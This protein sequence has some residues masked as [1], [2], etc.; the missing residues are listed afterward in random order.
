[1]NYLEL[2]G[3]LGRLAHE[4]ATRQFISRYPGHHLLYHNVLRLSSGREIRL[5]NW[6]APADIGRGISRSDI[7]DPYISLLLI[8]LQTRRD[9]RFALEPSDI[10]R[11]RQPDLASIEAHEV[12]E[13][14][15][16]TPQQRFAGQEQLREYKELLMQGDREFLALGYT[17]RVYP[18]L[19]ER[20]WH[21]GTR[22]LPSP[23][24]FSLG[25]L[26]SV[27]VSFS[28]AGP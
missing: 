8:C 6:G 7:G 20:Y 28:R 27:A 9:A 14:K 24:R 5:G 4:A 25:P 23:E 19:R 22:F 15:P 2:R 3:L 1:M 11:S 26:G 13:I 16:D 21:G 18:K 10:G 12:Y 17:S